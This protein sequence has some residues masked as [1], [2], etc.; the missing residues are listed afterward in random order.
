MMMLGVLGEYLWRTLE[1]ARRRPIYFLEET[2]ET[3]LR[4]LAAKKSGEAFWHVGS[5]SSRPWWAF[6]SASDASRFFC[7][8]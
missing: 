5:A 6:S 1:A 2:A 4:H 8:K 3:T 7:G